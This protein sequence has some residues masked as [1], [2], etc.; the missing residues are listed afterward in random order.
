MLKG[1]RRQ[2]GLPAPDND[3]KGWCVRDSV[4]TFGQWI[5]GMARLSCATNDAGL[6]D[7]AILLTSE[8]EKTPG[9]DGNPH[10]QT[11]PWEKMSCGL[12]DLALYANYPHAL[13]I[14]ERITRWASANF[15]RSR[16]PATRRTVTDA[17]P[18]ER[19]SGTRCLG[20]I[21]TDAL[22]DGLYRR[23]AVWRLGRKPALQRHRSHA[24]GAAGRA[25]LLLCRLPRR[26]GRKDVLLGVEWTHAGQTVRLRQETTFPESDQTALHLTLESPAE[27]ALRIRVPSWSK[28][29]SVMVNGE[30]FTVKMEPTT[31]EPCGADGRQAMSLQCVSSA[32]AFGAG[33]SPAFSTRGRDVWPA[34]DG[35]AAYH[36]VAEEGI[37]FREIAQAIGTTL[38]VPVVSKAPTE[39]AKQFSF[40]AS[41]VAVDNP[42]SSAQTQRAGYGSASQR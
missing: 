34:D 13:E 7:K 12:V 19:S 36:A 20:R 37:P 31:W 29:A 10:M 5:S 35:P 33:R 32:C 6:R 16:S 2:A 23:G 26:H 27:F 21:Q 11:Y 42:V 18:T 40:L 1:F 3:M 17:D 15:D 14:L 39:A 25:F 41:F 22:P 9:A 38:K 8:W 30:Q 24:A 4:S 28:D